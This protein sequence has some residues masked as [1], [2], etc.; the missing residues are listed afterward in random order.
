MRRDFLPTMKLYCA[1]LERGDWT[2]S[3]SIDMAMLCIAKADVRGVVGGNGMVGRGLTITFRSLL[4]W[5]S[6]RPKIYPGRWKFII[7]SLDRSF[8]L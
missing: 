4:R 1:P 7:Q 3:D 2:P 6:Y 5:I 8:C